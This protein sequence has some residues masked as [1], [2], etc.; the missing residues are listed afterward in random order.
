MQN[1]LSL[2]IMN[3]QERAVKKF[4][5]SLKAY[6]RRSD[7]FLLVLCLTATAIGVLVISSAVRGSAGPVYVQIGATVIGLV[8]YFLFSVIDIDIIAE[9]WKPLTLFGLLLILSLRWIGSDT[10][11][12]KAWIRF[13]GIGIQPAEMIKIIFIISLAHLMTGFKEAE[14]LDHPVSMGLLLGFLMVHFALIVGVSHDTGSA[15]VYLFIFIVMIYAAGLKFYW[16]AGALALLVLAAPYI[17]YYIL[18]DNYRT[19]ILAIFI[20][21]EIDP[22]GRGVLWQTNLS[23]AAIAGGGILGQGLYRGEL[24]QSGKIPLQSSDFIFSVIGEE[25][26]IAGCAVAVGLLTVIIVHCIRVGLKSQ[27]HLGAL[28]CVGVAAMIAFQTLENVGMCIGVAPV[29][30][31]TLPFFSYGGSSIV[32]LYAAAGIVSG[33]KMKPRPTM[34]L[35]R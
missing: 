30:G 27:S 29:I 15:L 32:T 11:G 19:R 10:G 5:S 20:P 6:L 28:A 23:K 31:L 9:K 8:L 12:N 35:N 16:I 25:L 26:G 7:T 33:V 2:S 34:F 13:G 17:W 4:F 24:T 22:T 1:V 3:D 14:R 21:S 18:N